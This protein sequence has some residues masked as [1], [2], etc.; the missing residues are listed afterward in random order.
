MD[1]PVGLAYRILFGL[2][3]VVGIF[4]I[5]YFFGWRN[6][7]DILVKYQSQVK[8]EGIDQAAQSKQKE[9]EQNEQT[10]AVADDYSTERTALFASIDRLRLNASASAV[11]VH[12]ISTESTN[13]A[14]SEFGSSCT[15]TFY[16]NALDDALRLSK[17]QEWALRQ[18]IPVE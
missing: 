13:A 7:H 17:W 6:Q 2:A 12:A 5:G 3:V 15:S 4:A 10:K 14:P 8:Q 9:L 11:P 18:H 16:A 1:T